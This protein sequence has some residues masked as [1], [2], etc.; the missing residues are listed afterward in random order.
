MSV[1]YRESEFRSE[2]SIEDFL[3]VSQQAFEMY[4]RGQI[5]NPPRSEQVEEGFFRLQMDAEWADRYRICKI[6]EER[7]DVNQGEL[8]VRRAVITLHD[9]D[10]KTSVTMDADYI[11]DMRTGAAGALGIKYLTEGP[12]Q[13]VGVVGTGRVARVLAL[14]ADAL[15]RPRE[16]SVTSRS[17]S[18]RAN[19]LE[20]VGPNVRAVLQMTPSL[21]ECLEGVDA[22]LTAVP[23]PRPI[24]SMDQVAHIP[25]LSVM[26][27]DG[28]SRQLEQRIM[29]ERGILVD[30]VQQAGASG[31]F[32][33]AEATG[34]LR[35]VRFAH[36]STGEILH[37]G[38]AACD[39]LTEADE[40]PRV[41]YFTG[42]AALDLCAAVMIYEG[43]NSQLGALSFPDS[44]RGPA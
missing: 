14:A 2:F 7:S 31:E 33:E 40:R 1:D 16:M 5:A 3:T 6:I 42:L 44:K 29:E 39:R 24:L 32:K 11:T 12:V 20:K 17:A 10:A 22:L 26:A 9:L 34:R 18:K 13:R 8:G 41:A 21:E 28:R 19:F 36:T 23:T 4:G 15:F 43:M 27:G 35:Q 37:I 30:S 38:H 25:C